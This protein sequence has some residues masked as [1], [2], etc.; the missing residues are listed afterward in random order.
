MKTRKKDITI[1]VFPYNLWYKEEE[2]IE[3]LFAF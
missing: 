1:S 3:I 2:K